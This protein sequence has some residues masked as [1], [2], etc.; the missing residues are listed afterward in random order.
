MNS[1]L[2]TIKD[3]HK[4]IFLSN[5]N[6]LGVHHIGEHQDGAYAPPGVGR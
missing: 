3:A 5:L 2:I 1:L 4:N 6:Y